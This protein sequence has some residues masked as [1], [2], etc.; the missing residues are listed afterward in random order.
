[1]ATRPERLTICMY[2]VGFGDCFL[3]TFHYPGRTRDRHVLIDFGTTY[4]KVDL[5]VEVARDIAERCEGRLDAVVATHRHRDHISGFAT[6]KAGDNGEVPGRIIAALKP[7]IVVMPWTEDPEAA[8]DARKA[9]RTLSPNTA[10]V[11]A[12]AEM[13]AFAETVFEKSLAEIEARKAAGQRATPT[14]SQLRFLGENNLSNKSAVKNLLKMGQRRA[15]VNYGSQSGLERLL[16]GVSTRVLG[17]PTLEQSESIRRQRAE[18]EAEFWHFQAL[19]G[20]TFQSES[21]AVFDPSWIADE[22]PAH[23]RWLQS[24][25]DRMRTTQLL[26]IVRILDRAMN[27]TS[28]ILLFEA[29]GKKFLFPGD[30]QIENWSYAL[31]EAPKADENRAAL[32]EVNLYKVGHHGSL[33]ATPK[34]LWELFETKS[35]RNHDNRLTTLLSS[36]HG[37][38]G[39]ASHGT[40]VPRS[41]LMDE[42]QK[43]STLL[44][45]CENGSRRKQLP[46]GVVECEFEL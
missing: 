18:D 13:Q 37:V 22:A 14:L 25:L 11:A 15:F 41:K 39:R 27:N 38:H 45:T 12:L 2:Q 28:V 46:F 23:G 30:A 9:T 20:R 32:A 17:P 10:H 8:R 1:M 42:L 7:K 29:G 26:Q 44:T 34:T 19:A 35:T 6:D 31:F 43:R 5:M 21:N 33:N 36:R 40:E 16:P 4:Q 3:L 24:R